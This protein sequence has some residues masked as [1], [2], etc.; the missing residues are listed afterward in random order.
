LGVGFSVERLA[1]M[2]SGQGFRVWG[3]RLRV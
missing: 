3:F 2:V 1:L